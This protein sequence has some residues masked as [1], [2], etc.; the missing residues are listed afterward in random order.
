MSSRSSSLLDEDD[1]DVSK[2]ILSLTPGSP[3]GG[4]WIES[5]GRCWASVCGGGGGGSLVSG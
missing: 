3:D 1:V 4:G 2:L 5:G